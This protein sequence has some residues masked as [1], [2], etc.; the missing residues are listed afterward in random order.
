MQSRGAV[1]CGWPS[2]SFTKARAADVKV[3]PKR[4]G[5][6]F[7]HAPSHGIDYAAFQGLDQ[8]FFEIGADYILGRITDELGVEYVRVSRVGQVWPLTLF[9]ALKRHG[10]ARTSGR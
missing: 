2:R 5:P 9:L 8:V 4:S 6:H 3:P 7:Q 10:G 1:A